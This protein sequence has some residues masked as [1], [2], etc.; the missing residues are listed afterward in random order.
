MEREIT[1]SSFAVKNVRGNRPGDF[2]TRF[3]PTVVLENDATYY[4][5]FNRIISMFLTWTNINS[6]Y[7]NQKIAFSKNNGN[8]CT[9]ID[10]AQGVWTYIDFHNYIKAKTK[11]ID[12]KGKEDYPI[13][14]TFDDPTF[15]VII[16]LETGYQLELTKSNFNELIGYD[17]AI[18]KD[19][20]NIGV[21]V[22]NVTEDTD[23]LNIHC[24]LTSTS[25]VAGEE[26]DIIYSFGTSTLKASYAFVLEPRRVIFNPVN[27]TSISS[28]RIYITDGLRRPVDLNNADTAFSLILKKV[29][30]VQ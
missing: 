27:K 14:L 28:I 13:K 19:E 21:R 30:S 9:D 1:L 25:L 22:P 29:A 12:S 26:S 15:R 24:D 16:T 5:G 17:K 23:V 6:G 8:S 7:N 18:L 20:R 11:T 10:F 2:T 3:T 4:I